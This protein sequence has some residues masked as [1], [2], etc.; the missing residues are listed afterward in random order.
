MKHFPCLRT[1]RLSLEEIRLLDIPTI[2]RYAGDEQVARST[3]NLPHPYREQDAI[4]WINKARQG[5]DVKDHFVFGVRL[6]ET[7]EFMG[8]IGLLINKR[9]N[10]AEIGYWIGVPFWNKGYITEA[11]GAVLKF[12]FE[13]LNLNKISAQYLAENPASGK[14]MIK[15]GMI[16]EAELVDHIRK[17]G[18]YKTSI[19]YRLTKAEYEQLAS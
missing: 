7:D 4:F 19:Q 13:E 17:Y 5:F 2:V 18:E 10:K 1:D 11:T 15:N 14:V 16:K 9:F 6:A 8:G 3:L 12:G